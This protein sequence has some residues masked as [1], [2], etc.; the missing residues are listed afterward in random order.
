MIYKY[1]LALLCG[2]LTSCCLVPHHTETTQIGDYEIDINSNKDIDFKNILKVFPVG[3]RESE[4]IEIGKVRLNKTIKHIQWVPGE[5]YIFYLAVY[6]DDCVSRR[7]K[8]CNI[9]CKNGLIERVEIIL[10]SS[11]L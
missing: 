6:A 2:L 3:T 4:I 9:Y 10:T 8:D 5:P 7:A 1:I 11:S